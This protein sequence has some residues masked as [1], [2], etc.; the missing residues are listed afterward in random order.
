MWQTFMAA[1][2][3]SLESCTRASDEI[4][5]DLLRLHFLLFLQLNAKFSLFTCKYCTWYPWFRLDRV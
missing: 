1:P 3:H 5:S 4:H 2:S